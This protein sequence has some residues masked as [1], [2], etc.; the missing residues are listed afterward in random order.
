M[1]TGDSQQET[2]Q[3]SEMCKVTTVYGG[4]RLVSGQVFTQKGAISPV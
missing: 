1:F 2:Y 3:R 4:T